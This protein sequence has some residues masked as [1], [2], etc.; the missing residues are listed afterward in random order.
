MNGSEKRYL[1]WLGTTVLNWRR[2][3]ESRSQVRFVGE[4]REGG[5][6]HLVGV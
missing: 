2:N 1:V 4:K 3:G 6:R 5:R